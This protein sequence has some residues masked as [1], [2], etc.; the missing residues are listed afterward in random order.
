MPHDT[1]ATA[2]RAAILALLDR[3]ADA[4]TRK[5][6]AAIAAWYAPNALLNDLAPQLAHSGL[7]PAALQAWLDTWDGPITVETRDPMVAT[8][9]DL[10]CVAA[11]TRMAGRQHGAATALW[12]RA[13]HIHARGTKG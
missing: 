1:Q 4:H 11:L 2:D 9:E 12:F 13:I 10:A 3:L 7:D 8:A 5:D 6:A